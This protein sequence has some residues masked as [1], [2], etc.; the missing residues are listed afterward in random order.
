MALRILLTG[1]TGMVGEGVLMEALASPEV[2]R[3]LVLG[4]RSC[5]VEH[6]KLRE[7]V[8]GN[9]FDLCS[10]ETQLVG[11]DACFFCLGTTSVGKKEGAY[12]K[13]TYDLTMAIAQTLARLDPETTF[14]YISGKG[15]D[16]SEHGRLMWARI[17]GK[18][19]NELQKLSFKASYAL[20][21]GII[22]AT[23]GQKRTLNL[24]RYFAWLFPII[25]ILSPKNACTMRELGRAMV[26]V[27]ANGYPKPVLEVPDI[28]AAARSYP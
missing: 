9:L 3:V 18:T 19:E 24:Y 4:R 27:A 23:K 14:C 5:E 15:T 22:Q 16:S 6:P 13:I 21:P 17:K 26:H 11:Y 12:R 20:R 1:A 10:I 7:I 25:R 8:H 2:E 28:V